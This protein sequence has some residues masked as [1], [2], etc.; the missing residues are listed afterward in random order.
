MRDVPARWL[1][2][3]IDFTDV[4]F[5]DVSE[6]SINSLVPEIGAWPY[7]RA[8]YA[9]VMEF[10]RDAGARSVTFDPQ[11]VVVTR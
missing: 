5:V 8:V 6:Q 9:Q 10:L 7:S 4:I 11:S 2:Q 3:D 1:A